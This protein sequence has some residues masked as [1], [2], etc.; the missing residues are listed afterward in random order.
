MERNA[1]EPRQR[2]VEGEGEKRHGW[3]QLGYWE[4]GGKALGILEMEEGK[5]VSW[6]SLGFYF[7]ASGDEKLGMEWMMGYG[8]ELGCWCHR[9]Y[10]TLDTTAC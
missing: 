7:F 10:S 2:S 1:K 6:A 3:G 5:A 4:P 9:H 8:E